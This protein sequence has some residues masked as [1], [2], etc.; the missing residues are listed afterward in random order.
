MTLSAPV[1][2]GGRTGLV[3]HLEEHRAELRALLPGRDALLSA[4]GAAPRECGGSRSRTAFSAAA[5][6][7]DAGIIPCCPEDLQTDT[8]ESSQDTGQVLGGLLDFAVARIGGPRRKLAEWAA[9]GQSAVVNAVN[10]VNAEERPTRAPA[11]L[12]APRSGFGRLDGLRTFCVGEGG[13]TAAFLAGCEVRCR[14]APPSRGRWGCPRAGRVRPV[15]AWG[16]AQLRGRG[17]RA[18]PATSA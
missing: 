11:D 5:L 2:A 9:G 17:C 16:S 8:A 12:G 15:G 4:C 18:G 13:N 1:E 6:R 14:S 7:L 10:A 3:G